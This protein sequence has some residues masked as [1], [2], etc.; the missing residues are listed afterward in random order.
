SYSKRAPREQD[1]SVFLTISLNAR[2]RQE[3]LVFSNSMF[4]RLLQTSYVL[5][6]GSR[7]WLWY[8]YCFNRRQLQN[9]EYPQQD[10]PRFNDRRCLIGGLR[11]DGIR[12]HD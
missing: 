8:D 5:L 4:N 9:H 12:E 11:S 1:P 2:L 7:K 3:T 6:P 10:F